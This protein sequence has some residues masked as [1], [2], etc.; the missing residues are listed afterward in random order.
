MAPSL[1]CQ[2]L[3]SVVDYFTFCQSLYSVVDRFTQYSYSQIDFRYMGQ[4]IK[5]ECQYFHKSAYALN[6]D[7]TFNENIELY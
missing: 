7:M 6:K 1:F 4:N 5:V 2:S 3:N